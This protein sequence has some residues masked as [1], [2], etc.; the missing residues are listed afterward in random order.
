MNLPKEGLKMAECLEDTSNQDT[1]RNM[2][3]CSF[4]REQFDIFKHDYREAF[5]E[6][7]H[8]TLA[9]LSLGPELKKE[10]VNTLRKLQK[11]KIGIER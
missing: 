10:V 8:E 5:D 1:D 3:S 4:L 2:D 7:G 6:Y 9:N 11:A